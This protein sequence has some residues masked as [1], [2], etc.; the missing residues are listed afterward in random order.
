MRAVCITASTKEKEGPDKGPFLLLPNWSFAMNPDDICVWPC[1]T[2][3][4]A[5]EAHEHTHLSD[6]YEVIAEDSDEYIKFMEDN[7]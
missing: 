5:C 2:W 3:C 4:Y 1:G 7:A 6:D